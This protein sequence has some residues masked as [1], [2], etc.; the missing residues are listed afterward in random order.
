[1]FS[2][3]AQ[4]VASTVRRAF[5]LVELLVVIGIIAVLISILL[6]ALSKARIAA[7]R[8][9]CLSN[10]RQVVNGF[11]QYVNDNNSRM[12]PQYCSDTQP[13]S[14]SYPWYTKRYIGQYVGNT[15]ER[16][17]GNSYASTANNSTILL[18]PAMFTTPNVEGL[19]I[20]MNAFWDSG[21]LSTNW[22]TKPYTS[23]RRPAETIMFVD[24]MYDSSGYQAYLI[25][26][27]YQGDASTRSWAGS[28]RCVA[29]RHGKQTVLSFADGHCDTLGVN[30]EDADSS[31]I[32]DGLH[33][34]VLTGEIKYKMVP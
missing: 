12:P 15:R 1:M 16:A 8:T 31:H 18:C 22:K 5:T 30:Q 32:N 13:T 14:G 24:V 29:Y 21:M 25:E 33:K 27:L 7:M 3:H 23:I 19:G 20:G 2:L 34:A 28:K 4:P 10:H 11:L 17:P 9:Q 26:Q 6:P